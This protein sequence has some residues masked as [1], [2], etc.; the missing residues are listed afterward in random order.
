MKKYD[1]TSKVYN[2]LTDIMCKSGANQDDMEK[3][4]EFFLIHFFDDEEEAK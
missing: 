3:A 1:I 2:A 4:I